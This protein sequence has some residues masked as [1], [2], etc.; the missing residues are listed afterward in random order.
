M[1]G[2]TNDE[3]GEGKL[4]FNLANFREQVSELAKE[5]ASAGTPAEAFTLNG[6]LC[7]ADLSEAGY[8]LEDAGI[9][10]EADRVF[11]LE[12]RELCE[13]IEKLAEAA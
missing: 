12:I 4:F 6:A 2:K 3:N 1:E 5:R 8:F 11:D 10:E 13:A 7:A 9:V